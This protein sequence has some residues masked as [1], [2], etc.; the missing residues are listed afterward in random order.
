MATGRI[1]LLGGLVAAGVTAALAIGA[2]VTENELLLRTALAFVVFSL[3]TKVVAGVMVTLIPELIDPRRS[4]RR[5]PGAAA[6]PGRSASPA[7]SPPRDGGQAPT[8][9]RD[10]DR[11]GRL[12][13]VLPGTSTE[14]ILD[15]NADAGTG[16]EVAG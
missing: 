15:A 1:A 13:V 12:N 9:A 14:D 2:E 10:S 7:G 5:G 16:K 8:G 4:K 3:L 6:G 11:G